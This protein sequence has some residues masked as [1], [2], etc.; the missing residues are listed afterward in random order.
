MK[1]WSHSRNVREILS[2]VLDAT[3]RGVAWTRS[4]KENLAGN[5]VSI[6]EVANKGE[7]EGMKRHVE[8]YS[9]NEN[10]ASEKRW[11]CKWEVLEFLRRELKRARIQT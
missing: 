4:A 1:Y 10:E 11:C 5:V 9:M 2:W 3:I 7:V 6:K 8:V